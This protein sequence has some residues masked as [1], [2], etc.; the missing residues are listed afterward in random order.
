M[1]KQNTQAVVETENGRSEKFSIN[2][3]LRQG[4]ALS[5][6]LFNLVLEDIIRKLDTRGNIT[7]N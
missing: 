6:L 7:Q 3:G 5:T 1:T 2:T 4:D